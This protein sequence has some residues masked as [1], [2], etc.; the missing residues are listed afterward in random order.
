MRSNIT[1]HKEGDS[2]ISNLVIKNDNKNHHIRKY[3]HLRL[4]YL[5]ENK[6]G[7]Y[8]ELIMTW[9]LANHLSDVD[10]VATKIVSDTVKKL[11][12]QGGINEELK[13]TN[14][15]EWVQ[16]MNNIKNRAEKIIFKKLIYV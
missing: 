12:E 9:Q 6:R 8:I 16:A 15:L 4:N 1:Y 13:A 3:G 5:K 7:F 14:Q 2:L 11:S 10:K